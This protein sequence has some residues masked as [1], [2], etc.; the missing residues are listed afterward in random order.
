MAEALGID[1]DWEE[2]DPSRGSF[3]HHM[4]AGSAAG[5]SEHILMFPLDTYKVCAYPQYPQM[6]MLMCACVSTAL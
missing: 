1:D 3:V 5:V 6:P 4:I 2:W